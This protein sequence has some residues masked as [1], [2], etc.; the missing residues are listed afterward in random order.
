ML[1][2]MKMASMKI[3]YV[4][5]FIPEPDWKTFYSYLLIL[6]YQIH[7]VMSQGIKFVIEMKF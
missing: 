6:C 4:Y 2:F 3:Y 5:T 1:T 7:S